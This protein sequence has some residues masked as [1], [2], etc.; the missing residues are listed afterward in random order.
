MDIGDFRT[1]FG[2]AGDEMRNP[3]T[4]IHEDGMVNIIDLGIFRRNFGK[5]AE[6]DCTVMYRA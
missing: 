2:K 5:T 4:D 3:L 1:D 6:K